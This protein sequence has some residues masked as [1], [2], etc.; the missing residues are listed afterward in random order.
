[1]T[2]RWMCWPTW[3]S[4]SSTTASCAPPTPFERLN[5]EIKRRSEVVGI[6]PNNATVMR[7]I[8]ALLL[9]QNDEWVVQRARYMTLETTTPLGDDLAVSPP[10]LAA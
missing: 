4:R 1:M 3:G 9:L 7:L 6:F 10:P 8:G 5:G 2:P